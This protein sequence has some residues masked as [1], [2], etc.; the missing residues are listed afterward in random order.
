V[1]MKRIYNIVYITF[2]VLMIFSFSFTIK[3][4]H[5]RSK[6]NKEFAV[7][8]QSYSELNDRYD[9]RLDD[10]QKLNDE[11]RESNER[12]NNIINQMEAKLR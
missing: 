12:F 4:T 2:I 7:I 6:L 1:K 11:R 9:Q 8:I 10:Q 3:V 5:D